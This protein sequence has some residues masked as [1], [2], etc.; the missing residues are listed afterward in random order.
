MTELGRIVHINVGSGWLR[1]VERWAHAI[2][3]GAHSLLLL[4]VSCLLD[5]LRRL[6]LRV[7]VSAMDST[8]YSPR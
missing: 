1:V 3:G 6:L 2:L 7:V 5:T 4:L 8:G